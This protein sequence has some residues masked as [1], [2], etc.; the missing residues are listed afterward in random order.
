MTSFDELSTERTPAEFVRVVPHTIFDPKWGKVPRGELAVGFVVV[1]ESDIKAARANADRLASQA[2]PYENLGSVSAW[3]DAYE[4]H[5]MSWIVL[6]GTCDPNDINQPW[7]FLPRDPDRITSG[8][9]TSD[10]LKH[11]F[12]LYERTRIEADPTQPPLLDGE[13]PA[14][15]EALAKLP[16]LEAKDRLRVQRARR[17]LG[18]VFAELLDM[19]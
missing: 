1:P 7:E 2:H 15:I 18:F 12:D 14:F 10:G 9:L 3:V 11:L 4:S 13:M 19:E 17:L 6:Y 5:L 16:A 8:C